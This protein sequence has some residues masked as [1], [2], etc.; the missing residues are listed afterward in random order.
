MLIVWLWCRCRTKAAVCRS[1]LVVCVSDF[2]LFCF[3]NRVRERSIRISPAAGNVLNVTKAKVLHQR[4][5]TQSFLI[6]ICLNFCLL[7]FRV[8]W[9]TFFVFVAKV[10]LSI[11]CR[12]SVVNAT[13]MNWHLLISLPA[14]RKAESRRVRHLCH[15]PNL[16]TKK[17]LMQAKEQGEGG[18]ADLQADRRHHHPHRNCYCSISR[19][20]KEQVHWNSDLRRE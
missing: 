12:C 17:A 19:V 3:R 18:A 15:S 10:S 9:D 11:T 5:K 7:V 4:Y 6:L 16:H 8:F 14:T 20:A 1:D 13:Q 2:K